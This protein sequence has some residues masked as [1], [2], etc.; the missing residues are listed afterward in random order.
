MKTEKPDVK[1]RYQEPQNGQPGKWHMNVGKGEKGP[2]QYDDLVVGQGDDGIFV[3]QIQTPHIVFDPAKAIEIKLEG[4][5]TDL[6]KQ[7]FYKVEQGDKLIVADPNSDQVATKY[8]YKLNFLSTQ[9]SKPNPEPLDPVI[10]NGCCK[11][12]VGTPV[13]GPGT[14]GIQLM[15]ATGL[16]VVLVV[17]LVLTSLYIAITRWAK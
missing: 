9:A 15:S 13:A 10:T 3:F 11:S 6:S 4:P 2:G 1:L 7:F 8:Y 14:G 16:I 17:S 5:G 12:F